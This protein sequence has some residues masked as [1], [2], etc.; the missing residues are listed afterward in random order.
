[1][2]ENENYLLGC[3]LLQHTDNDLSVDDFNDYKNQ[4][5]FTAIKVLSDS[6][7]PIDIMTVTSQLRRVNQLTEV[8]EIK[9]SELIGIVSSTSNYEFYYKRV[10]ESSN[11]RDN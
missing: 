10:K 11:L 7:E 4:L 9:L 1:M 3:L 5:I 2:L 8:G 6:G